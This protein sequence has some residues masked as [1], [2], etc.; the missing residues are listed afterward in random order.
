MEISWRVHALRVVYTSLG[1][2]EHGFVVEY[3][4]FHLM[5]VALIEIPNSFERGLVFIGTHIT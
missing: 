4:A 5:S 3:K 2:V 1:G